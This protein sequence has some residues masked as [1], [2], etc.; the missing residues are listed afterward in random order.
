MRALRSARAPRAFKC[1]AYAPSGQIATCVDTDGEAKPQDDV[2]GQDET[3]KAVDWTVFRNI[4]ISWGVT[5]PVGALLS[6]LLTWVFMFTVT[7]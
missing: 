5:V 7:D 2:E 3:K 4:A 6:A 1:P